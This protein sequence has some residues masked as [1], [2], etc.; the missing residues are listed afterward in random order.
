MRL[1]VRREFLGLLEQDDAWKAR[2]LKVGAIRLATNQVQVELVH[3]RF[4]DRPARL[5]FQEMSGKILASLAPPNWLGEL[6][7]SERRALRPALKMLFEL[8]GA[9]IPDEA[10][11]DER[12]NGTPKSAGFGVPHPAA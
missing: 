6:L 12:P 9:D 8:A 1:F 3:E 4:A 2:P 10:S 5:Q 7:E 11:L